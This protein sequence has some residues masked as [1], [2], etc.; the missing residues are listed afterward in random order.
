MK[1]SENVAPID[2]GRMVKNGIVT[3]MLLPAFEKNGEYIRKQ[4]LRIRNQLLGKNG[5]G[6]PAG[7]ADALY[8]ETN[9]L[10]S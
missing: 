6:V 2:T 3:G 9:F 10:G 1:D 4:V 8:P 7:T 5:M